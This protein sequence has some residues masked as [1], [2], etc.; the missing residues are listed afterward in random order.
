ML[1]PL[2]IPPRRHFPP[3]MHAVT[4]KNKHLSTWRDERK[5]PEL[6]PDEGRV[7]ETESEVDTTARGVEDSS[8]GLC[9]KEYL[10]QCCNLPTQGKSLI[11]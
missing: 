7:P 8:Q 1:A 3:E 9:S 5:D 11:E 4:A 10:L 2:V 6:A